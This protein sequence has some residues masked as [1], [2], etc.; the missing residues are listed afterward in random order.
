MNRK[1]ILLEELKKKIMK[2][3]FDVVDPAIFPVLNL[4]S[5]QQDGPEVESKIEYLLNLDDEKLKYRL[6]KRKEEKVKDEEAKEYIEAKKEDVEVDKDF[7]EDLDKNNSFVEMQQQNEEEKKEEE[8]R[9]GAEAKDDLFVL[10]QEN[11]KFKLQDREAIMKDLQDRQR[12]VFDR[13]LKLLEALEEIRKVS[14]Q[15]DGNLQIDLSHMLDLDPKEFELQKKLLSRFRLKAMSTKSNELDRESPE[16]EITIETITKED[17]ENGD[18][19][20]SIPFRELQSPE[21]VSRAQAFKEQMKEH[22]R[23][24]DIKV[25]EKEPVSIEDDVLNAIAGRDPNRRYGKVIDDNE[26]DR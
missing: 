18:I 15:F 9:E 14:R 11:G 12:N 24:K 13:N 19:T 6:N 23:I 10:T 4:L 20:Y 17:L 25:E 26:P 2:M 16:R 5:N 8:T 21:W 1:N 3:G 7:Q 22:L